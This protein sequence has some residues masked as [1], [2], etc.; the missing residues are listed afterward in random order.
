[1]AKRKR[2]SSGWERFRRRFNRHYD[3]TACVVGSVCV[4]VSETILLLTSM[5]RWDMHE[6]CV[7]N[8]MSYGVVNKHCSDIAIHGKSFWE[9]IWI[10][11]VA[12]FNMVVKCEW[13][14]PIAKAI[15]YG[16]AMVAFIFM[17]FVIFRTLCAVVKT[18]VL[19]R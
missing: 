13:I 19:R 15:A 7:F 14:I 2:K 16:A 1:M 10:N 4:M 5:G 18:L 6:G 11:H 3:S 9:S 12:A 8:T 17:I